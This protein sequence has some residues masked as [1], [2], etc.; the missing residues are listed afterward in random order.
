MKDQTLQSPY[1]PAAQWG[2]GDYATLLAAWFLG[3]LVAGLFFVGG[4]ASDEIGLVEL[5]TVLTGQAVAQIGVL[6]WISRTRGTGSWAS[7]FGVSIRIGDVWG[8]AAGFGLQLFVALAIGALIER[9]G[10]ENPPRQG[11][12]EIA[13]NVT[14][15]VGTVVFIAL[16]VVVA[17][18]IEEIVY[19]GVLLSRLRR[20]MGPNASI[21]I[22]AA[23]FAAIH[24]ADPNA[25]FAV[26]GLFI[27]GVALGWFALRTGSLS[28][29]FFVHAGVNLTGALVLIFGADAAQDAGAAAFLLF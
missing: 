12:T 28:V 16:V 9:F 24:L 27:I 2:Y 3:A 6:T 25:I 20:S 1:L 14:G 15:V 29:P 18:L 23:V 4:D 5:S 8:V 26:P 21:V 11:I 7:D 13:E 10:P 17:P 22:S 19:R